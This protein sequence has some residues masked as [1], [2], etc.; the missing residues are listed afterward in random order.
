MTDYLHPI[1]AYV[2]TQNGYRDNNN[3]RPGHAAPDIV[4]TPDN[5]VDSIVD[6]PDTEVDR[7]RTR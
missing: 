3:D 2:A 1:A 7:G 4:A 5:R 6:T